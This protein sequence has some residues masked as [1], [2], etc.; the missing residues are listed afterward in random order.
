MVGTAVVIAAGQAGC[1]NVIDSN[2]DDES[3]RKG[4]TDQCFEFGKK[5]Y[6]AIINLK[7]SAVGRQF[8]N[9][10]WPQ[11]ELLMNAT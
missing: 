1:S 10:V 3:Y 8:F 2:N 6:V 11:L 7:T 5:F 9:I 4:T